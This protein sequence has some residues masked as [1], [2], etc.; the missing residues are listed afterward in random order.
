LKVVLIF[1]E[2]VFLA[3]LGVPKITVG[4]GFLTDP[5]RSV[6][7]PGFIDQRTIDSLELSI[8]L[9]TFIVGSKGI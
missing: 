2:S 8:A 6:T 1:H 5:V 4:K 7:K 3:D 9:R